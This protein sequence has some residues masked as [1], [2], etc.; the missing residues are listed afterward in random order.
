VLVVDDEEDV[1]DS[2]REVPE[3]AG[4]DVYCAGDGKEAIDLLGAWIRRR[5]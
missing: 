1:R 3:E 4:Y 2:L 5:G